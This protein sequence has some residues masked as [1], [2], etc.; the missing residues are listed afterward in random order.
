MTDPS[1]YETWVRWA[2]T[3]RMELSVYVPSCHSSTREAVTAKGF[4]VVRG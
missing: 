4:D 3:K 1:M 2:C